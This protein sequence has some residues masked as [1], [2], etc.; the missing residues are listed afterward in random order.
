M[1]IPETYEEYLKTPDEILKKIACREKTKEEAERLVSFAMRAIEEFKDKDKLI[2][3]E[4]RKSAKS[5]WERY[6][7]G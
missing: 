3:E 2:S 7:C 5:N 4:K 1:K 6:C